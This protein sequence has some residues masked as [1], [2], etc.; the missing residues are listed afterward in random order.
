[1]GQKYLESRETGIFGE[2]HKWLS[3]LLSIPC[4]TVWL[5]PFKPSIASDWAFPSLDI[6]WRY[7]RTRA[8][9]DTSRKVLRSIPHNR[10]KCLSK[11]AKRKL[12]WHVHTIECFIASEMSALKVST[13]IILENT[14]WTGGKASCAIAILVWELVKYWKW[15][16]HIISRYLSMATSMNTEAG[17]MYAI[18]K[19]M[20]AFCREGWVGYRGGIQ[21]RHEGLN[22]FLK[23]CKADVAIYSI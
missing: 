20:S 5:S 10:E 6:N 13:W 21:R 9:G 4:I 12:F 1:M 3:L 17:S 7:F 22:G 23:W 8:K 11:A 18:F 2:W 14:Q 16:L 19:K 15:V